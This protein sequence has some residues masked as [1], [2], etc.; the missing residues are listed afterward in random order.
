MSSHGG[1]ALPSTPDRLIGTPHLH[2]V[3]TVVRR[4][5]DQRRN[6]LVDVVGNGEFSLAMRWRVDSGQIVVKRVPPFRS[7]AAA[8]EYCRVTRDYIE[9]IEE[10]GVACVRTEVL[11]H[12]RPDGSAVVYHCQPLMPPE[13]LVSNILK[14]QTPDAD[15]PVVE[16][17]VDAAGKVVRP[18]V[19]FDAQA[20]NWV[21]H[22]DRVW[23]LDLSTPFLLDE[24][25][26]VRFP[27]DGFSQEYPLLVRPLLDRETR[28]WLP[29]YTEL[30]F[31]LYD[32][33]ALLHRE[34]LE[35]WCEPF[36]AAIRRQHSI[37][38]DIDRARD[39]FRSDARF[40]PVAHALR[41]FQRLW[42]QRTG[43]RYESLLTNT[44][45]YGADRRV[46]DDR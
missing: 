4:A 27:D 12:E 19:A 2:E 40:Y 28:K 31:V 33:V 11:T 39:N 7:L 5:I 36:A 30:E 23:Y 14:A 24:D 34:A 46:K 10:S 21:W 3:E 42:L 25:D 32:L 6:D 26:R 1:A 35:N 38:I 22:G 45:S 43:R 41:K 37:D 13:S 16:A 29:R 18:G 44:S 9:V 20:S 15:H 17:I 8:A